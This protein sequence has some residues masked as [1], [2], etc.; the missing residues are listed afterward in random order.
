MT[1]T[2]ISSF[3]S[4][5]FRARTRCRDGKSNVKLSNVPEGKL[6][7]SVFTDIAAALAR[8]KVITERIDNA[9]VNY[10]VCQWASIN[11]SSLM[12]D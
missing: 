5:R 1:L 3:D 2:R 4:S 9:V 7:H 11:L 8:D 10:A 6:C 12:R